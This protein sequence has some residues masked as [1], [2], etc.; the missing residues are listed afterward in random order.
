MSEIFV[1]PRPLYLIGGGARYQY[2]IGFEYFVRPADVFHSVNLYQRAIVVRQTVDT[3]V[4]NNCPI[5]PMNGDESGSRCTG[6]IINKNKKYPAVQAEVDEVL[7]HHTAAPCKNGGNVWIPLNL[8]T[9][10]CET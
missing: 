6:P 7:Y 4:C 5:R 8:S 10:F 2:V 3:S 9:T 1:K